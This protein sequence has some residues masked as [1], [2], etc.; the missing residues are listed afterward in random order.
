M[1][2]SM[3][4]IEVLVRPK[5]AS[6]T[7]EDLPPGILDF[8]VDG[9]NVTA[10]L[11]QG[12]AFALLAELCAGVVALSRGKRDRFSASFYSGD[13]AWEIGLETDASAVLVSVYRTAPSVLVAVHERR[14]ELVALREALLAATSETRETAGRAAA[15][16]AGARSS[17]AQPGPSYGRGARRRIAVKLSTPEDESVVFG[18]T[19]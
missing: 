16:L 12:A 5:P 7:P 6:L 10:R 1:G 13:E 8:I 14:V 4:A 11:G 15:S 19:L 9:I 17:L 18:T 3:P 2:T